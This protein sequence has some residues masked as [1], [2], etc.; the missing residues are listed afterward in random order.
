[1]DPFT[2]AGIAGFAGNLLNYIGV[3]QTNDVNRDIAHN[4]TVANMEEAA[5]NRAFQSSEALRQMAFQERMSSTA[6]QRGVQD[7]KAAGLNPILAALNTGASTPS[8]AAGSGSQGSAVTIPVQNALAAF[9]STASEIMGLE[10][11]NEE[12][13]LLKAQ[14]KKTLT[15]ARVIEKGI[16][17]SEIKNEVYDRIKPFLIN[18]LEAITPTSKEMHNRRQIKHFEELTGRKVKINPP[19]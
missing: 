7:L 4:A 9:T 19:R 1:M 5:K 10:R 12:I 8:G 2:I 6:H 18:I 14:R 16:P 17:E 15:E 11:A 3:R 13:S